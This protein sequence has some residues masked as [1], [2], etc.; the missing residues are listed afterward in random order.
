[1]ISKKRLK[2]GLDILLGEEKKVVNNSENITTA[3]TI[4]SIPISK[5]TPNT[6]QP[7]KRFNEEKILSCLLHRFCTL[8]PCL[9]S[10]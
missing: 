3:N 2:T 5:V 7:R 1:M 4:I 8:S 10:W 9:E 6:G